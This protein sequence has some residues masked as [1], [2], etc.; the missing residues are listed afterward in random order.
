MDKRIIIV[1]GVIVVLA[2]LAIIQTGNSDLITGMV[3]YKIT[4]SH[5]PAAIL[6]CI[7]LKLVAIA[8]VSFIF[9]IVFWETHKWVMQ[10]KK[11]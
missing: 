1:S 9:S 5:D 6:G 11:K 7:V 3:G 10:K 2:V 8:L 4:K